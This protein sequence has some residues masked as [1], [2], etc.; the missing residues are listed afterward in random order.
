MT[1][2]QFD[3]SF[4]SLIDHS[5]VNLT[6]LQ[7]YNLTGQQFNSSFTHLIVDYNFP[8]TRLHQKDVN[9]RNQTKSEYKKINYRSILQK[10][11]TVRTCR[12]QEQELHNFWISWPQQES[13]EI[14]VREQAYTQE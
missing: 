14:T 8:N 10:T 3:S 2:Q 1:V 13:K 5:T 4:D 6:I 9:H 7:F 12:R 11:Q